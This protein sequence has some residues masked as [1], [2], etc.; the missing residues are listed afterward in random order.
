[1]SRKY[2]FPINR[3]D[4]CG[5]F[6]RWEEMDCH[7]VPDTAF[8]SEDDSYLECRIGKG[9]KTLDN[10]RKRMDQCLKKI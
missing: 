8:S 10:I 3:A 7:F 4:C 5:K 9:C 6:R 2:P 1:M